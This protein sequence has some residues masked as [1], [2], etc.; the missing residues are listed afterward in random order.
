MLFILLCNIEDPKSLENNKI[1][2]ITIAP[3]KLPT[4]IFLRFSEPNV[5]EIAS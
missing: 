4:T 3:I 1:R 5:L 2:R